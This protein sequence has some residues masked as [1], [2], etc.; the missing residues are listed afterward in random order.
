MNPDLALAL[1]FLEGNCRPLALTAS[2]LQQALR[3]EIVGIDAAMGGAVLAFEPGAEF[4]QGN[5]VIQGGIVT[6]MLD[7]AL[8]FAA[9]VRA[10]ADMSVSSVTLT[11]NFIKPALPGRM[12]A[13]GTVIRMG[14]RMAFA[15]ARIGPDDINPVATAT[16][17]MA[18]VPMKR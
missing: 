8:A 4:T 14:S 12:I 13:R 18:V 2:P 11:V 10:P 7:F 17:V 9:L 15:E 1:E 6:T 5:G 3:G 16:T